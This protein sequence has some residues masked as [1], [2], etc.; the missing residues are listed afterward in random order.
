MSKEKLYKL[1]E[2]QVSTSLSGE[3]V[4]LN[5][6][7]GE[8]FSLNEV[9]TFIWGLIDSS[10]ITKRAL[11]KQVLENYDVNIDE[12]RNDIDKL[13]EALIHEGLLEEV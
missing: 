13:L 8:Y 3:S 11:E 6:A 12:C 5:H 4:I 7:K 2:K 1:S 10:G 9:G